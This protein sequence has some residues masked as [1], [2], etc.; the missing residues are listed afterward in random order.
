[1]T[2][3]KSGL[4]PLEYLCITFKDVIVSDIDI[5]LGAASVQTHLV[6]ACIQLPFDLNNRRN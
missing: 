5:S 6:P 3:R 1:M 2:K 4:L